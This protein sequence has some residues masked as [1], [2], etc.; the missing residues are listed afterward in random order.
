MTVTPKVYQFAPGVKTGAAIINGVERCMDAAGTHH[1]EVV[2]GSFTPDLTITLRDKNTLTRSL[3]LVAITPQNVQAFYTPP[4]GSES[5][6]VLMAGGLSSSPNT[7][8]NAQY[9]IS[10]NIAYVLEVEDAIFI[11]TNR[12]SDGGTLIAPSA[13]SW[14]LSAGRIYSAHNRSDAT[15]EEGVMGGGCYTSEANTQAWLS[16]DTTSAGTQQS[17]AWTGGSSFIRI[18]CPTAMNRHSRTASNTALLAD[19]GDA[20]SLIERLVPIPVS[21]PVSGATAGHFGYTRYWRARKTPW[22]GSVVTNTTILPSAGDPN[23]AWR[24][25]FYA[26]A[27]NIAINNILIWCP[28]GQEVI[29]P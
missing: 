2:P 10:T 5:G 25:Q 11:L 17:I 8:D 1:W 16:Q 13:M 18:C 14:S 21:G 29:V 6:A 27:T 26:S 7:L 15:F 24:H 28:S 22:D 20:A 23:I 12:G 3:R 4:G 9:G 19:I